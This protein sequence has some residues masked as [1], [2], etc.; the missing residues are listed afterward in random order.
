MESINLLYSEYISDPSYVYKS[1]S[2]NYIVILQLND[3]IKTNEKRSNVVNTLYAKHRAEKANVKLIFNKFNPLITIQFIKN[4][5]YENKKILYETNKEIIADSFDDNLNNVCSNG[6][7]YYK[8]IECAFFCELSYSDLML[9]KFNG[10]FLNYYDDGRLHISK[11]YLHGKL[12]GK[13]LEYFDNGILH[14]ESC[15]SV[16]KLS[17]NFLKFYKNGIR[18]IECNYEN[19]YIVGNHYMWYENNQLASVCTY[20][21]GLLLMSR[22]WTRNGIE[23]NC[24]GVILVKDNIYQSN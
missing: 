9:N 3:D 6:I 11:N 5:I 16:G 23:Q 1:C 12:N 2:K 8:S 10:V 17:G 4:S 7:H 22:H 18:W 19:N 20:K 15:Y 13:F 21:N 24:N 14:I